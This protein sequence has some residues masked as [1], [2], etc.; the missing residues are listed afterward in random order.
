MIASGEVPVATAGVEASTTLP[1]SPA[2]AP[3]RDAFVSVSATSDSHSPDA[4]EVL[5]VPSGIGSPVDNIAAASSATATQPPREAKIEPV[6]DVEDP[7]WTITSGNLEEYVGKAPFTSDRLY[8]T[9][10][11]GVVMG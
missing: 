9:T 5:S 10:P 11:P 6:I 4:A 3:L 7:A 1:L 2:N 8:A